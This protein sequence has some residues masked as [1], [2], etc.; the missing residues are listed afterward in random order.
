MK[1]TTIT[2][3]GMATVLAVVMAGCSSWDSM[4]KRQKGAV[5]GAGVGG[6]AGAVITGGGVLG[7]VGGAAIGGVIGDQV[8]KNR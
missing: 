1:M 4:S 3:V 2:K 6:V 8:G 5:T 7:T